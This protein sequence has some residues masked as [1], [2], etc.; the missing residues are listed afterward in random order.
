M[1][2]VRTIAEADEIK[3]FD[4]EVSLISLPLAFG[5]TL[6]NVPA[7]IPYLRADPEH[8]AAFRAGFAD[9]PGTRRIGLC[10]WGSEHSRRSSIPPEQLAPL[11][12]LPDTRF[13]ALQPEI[14]A[15]QRRFVAARPEIVTHEG[16]LVD[17]DATAALI[18]AL[19]AV[20]TIDTSVAHLAG[21]LGKPVYLLLR[22][23]PDWRWM[24]D[25]ADSPWYPTARLFRQ[26]PERDW[27][28]PIRAVRAA[29]AVTG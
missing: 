1:K 11:L 3:G 8:V 24:R 21:A 7:A 25:R 26:G 2:G 14:P 15:D 22:F 12:D 19:D 29:L 4:A 10:W 18:A 5:T 16:E 27:A 28:A 20:V 17:F 13:H 23:S 9:T 6:A